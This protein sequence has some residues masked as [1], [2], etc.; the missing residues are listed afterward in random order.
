MKKLNLATYY[1]LLK[2]EKENLLL[3]ELND[4]IVVTN[5][6]TGNTYQVSK[7]YYDSH[8][9][10]YDIV[11]PK[12]VAK[13]KKQGISPEKMKPSKPSAEDI[14]SQSSIGGSKNEKVLNLGNYHE[15]S[16]EDRKRYRDH[17]KS[18]YPD[19]YKYGSLHSA[20]KDG[21]TFMID[22]G[23]DKPTL[24]TIPRTEQN[25]W[26]VYALE[27]ITR[28]KRQAKTRPSY[29]SKIL[30]PMPDVKPDSPQ[31]KDY[32]EKKF[33]KGWTTEYHFD[34]YDPKL[35]AKFSTGYMPHGARS[36][37]IK[38]PRQIQAAKYHTKHDESDW[39][40]SL[41]PRTS[42]KVRVPDDPY[43]S[44]DRS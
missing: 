13:M 9:S 29:K 36:V 35:G 19:I 24:K 42:T 34:S 2:Q 11:K 30:G 1:K 17:L 33:G 16:P 8:R 39:Y 7:P 37:R 3:I 14:V 38:D 5:K 32:L 18:K 6:K 4:K 41:K 12:D 20:D 23:R 27:L 31:A 43:D 28:A 10:D 21:T 40:K 25:D 15:A 22:N 44:K 26:E